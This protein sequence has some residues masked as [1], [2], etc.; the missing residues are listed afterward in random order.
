[1]FITITCFPPGI[2]L[3]AVFNIESNLAK[4]SPKKNRKKIHACLFMKCWATF[5][6]KLRVFSAMSV[7]MPYGYESNRHAAQ[8]KGNLR[9]KL[10]MSEGKKKVMHVETFLK[11]VMTQRSQYAIALEIQSINASLAL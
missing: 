6:Q 11:S 7:S 3:A 9:I 8:K 5:G 1:M 2:S 10:E 4:Y